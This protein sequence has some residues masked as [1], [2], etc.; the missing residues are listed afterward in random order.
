[1]SKFKVSEE[2]KTK[3]VPISLRPKHVAMLDDL[4]KQ[5]RKNRS[6]LIQDLIEAAYEKHIGEQVIT[7]NTPE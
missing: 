5:L 3:P 6:A 2:R 7:E 1:M 4:E